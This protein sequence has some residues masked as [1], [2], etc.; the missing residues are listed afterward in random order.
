MSL[1]PSVAAEPNSLDPGP[2]IENEI[3]T[4]RA[5]S[6][7]AITSLG[8]GLVS[9]LS[10]TDLW[11]LI[12]AGLAVVL[13]IWADFRIRRMSDVLTG[14]SYAH[15]GIAL[16]AVFGIAAAGYSYWSSRVLY[17]DARRFGLVLEQTLNTS[18]KTEPVDTADVI[19]YM[20]PPGM[21]KA[22][23][24][25]D[26][27]VR[28]Q[29]LAKETEKFSD[30]DSK[31]RQMCS[32]AGKDDIKFV[33]VEN[34]FF[35]ELDTFALIVYRIGENDGHEH[36]EGAEHQHKESPG[37]PEREG[38]DHAMIRVKGVQEGRRYKWYVDHIYYPY[39]RQTYTHVPAKPKDDGHGHA[40]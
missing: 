21:R 8:L 30:M 7:L 29:Q 26:A 17:A 12:T 1:N 22:I 15:A 4:Y 10:F 36:K 31:L 6:S 32:E 14:R 25:A 16:G 28:I 13:G 23:T 11:W 33:E 27:R 9:A 38:F 24:P 5:I 18:R 20:I 3:P 40:H 2:V 37:A 39:V 34:A 35:Q 19:W